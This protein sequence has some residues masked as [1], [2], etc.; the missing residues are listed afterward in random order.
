MTLPSCPT[1]KATYMCLQGSINRPRSPNAKCSYQAWCLSFDLC[2]RRSVH[3]IHYCRS[4]GS[5][6]G[7]NRLGGLPS[8]NKDEY[9]SR[10]NEEKLLLQIKIVL[11]TRHRVLEPN[12][13]GNV[14]WHDQDTNA[15]LCGLNSDTDSSY[16]GPGMLPLPCPNDGHAT[17]PVKFMDILIVHRN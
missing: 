5:C 8:G 3:S 13:L 15:Q 11:A 16:T 1:G 10:R 7:L 12:E 6:S 4:P 2:P 14:R 9:T 17:T